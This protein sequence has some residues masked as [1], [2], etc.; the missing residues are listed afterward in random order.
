MENKK[1]I[2]KIMKYIYFLCIGT[3]IGFLLGTV[4]RHDYRQSNVIDNKV[5]ETDT[6]PSDAFGWYGIPT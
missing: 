2:K 1:E 3:V 5:N 6:V 4:S